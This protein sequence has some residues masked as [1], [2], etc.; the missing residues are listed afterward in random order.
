MRWPTLVL[1]VLVLLL[2][3]PLWFGKGG[4]Y[5]VWEMDRQL[6]A[7]RE[8]NQHLEQRNAGLDAEVR[9]LK[10]GYDAIEERARYELGLVREGEVFVQ[11]P[12]Q[13][14]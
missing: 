6:A 3:Y 9:D 14:P 5:R 12:T 8:V 13:R 4:W 1:V 10:S 2:Q 7:Q 11:V